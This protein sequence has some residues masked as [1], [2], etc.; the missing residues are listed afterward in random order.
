MRLFLSLFFLTSGMSS[1]LYQTAWQRLLGLFY[2]VGAISSA[3]VIGAFLFGLGL[4]SLFGGQLGRAGR[5]RTL[6][7]YMSIELGIGLFGIVSVPLVGSLGAVTAGADYWL[8]AV[9]TFCFLLF[10]T[11]LMGATLPVAILAL[12]DF[13]RDLLRN[14]SSYYF[15]N[16]IGA[17]IGCF[18]AGTVLISLVGLNG[19]IYLAALLN[20]LLA[21]AIFGLVRNNTR[22][23]VPEQRTAA[24]VATESMP[25]H[26]LYPAVFVS[27]FIAIGYEIIW[28]R[29]VGVLLKDSIYTFT[30]ML[31]IYLAAIA[32]G[33]RHVHR[34]AGI[35]PWKG[36]RNCYLALNGLIA[37]AVAGTVCT[38]YYLQGSLGDFGLDQLRQAPILP[39]PPQQWS[40][41]A[42]GA[43]PLSLLAC[44]GV[45]GF[46]IALPAYFM[47]A[48]FPLLASLAPDGVRHPAK[49]V[50][51]VYATAVFGNLAGAL[52]TGFVLLPVFGTE[53]TMLFF[54]LAGVSFFIFL[55][56]GGRGRSGDILYRLVAP[57]ALVVVIFVIFPGPSAVIRSLHV[58][59][60]EGTQYFA[61]GIEGVVLTHADGARLRH[62]INGSAH[63]GRPNPFFYLEAVQTLSSVDNPHNVLIIGLGTGSVLEAAL[64]DPKVRAITLVEINATTIKNLRKVE[65]IEAMLSHPKVTVFHDD[66]RRWLNRTG[67][68]FDVVMMDPLRTA[69]AFSN[70]IY[71]R[72]FF[73][74][75]ETHLVPGGAV[76]V[77]TDEYFVV[78]RTL[79]TIFPV[80]EQYCTYLIGMRSPALNDLRAARFDS[81]VAGFSPET[82]VA[83]RSIDCERRFNRE[84]ILG[85]TAS[86]PINTDYSPVTEYYL[87]SAVSKLLRS[88]PRL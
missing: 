43:L 72:E 68:R 34:I 53:R 38:F 2:G 11:A 58:R 54:V 83:I 52:G 65:L 59:L 33:S 50:S 20:L 1:L 70:N 80:V 26:L 7:A 63:G 49:A 35:I 61:E 9:C 19:T 22:L 13:D 27:G 87:G 60:T 79:A 44:F 69:S 40:L 36:P 74:Q 51:K 39:V 64:N 31:S 57:A 77:W 85:R 88:S 75:L 18:V 37:L 41:L 3:I 14:V 5:T 30:I 42:I 6:I 81:I 28:F 29:L 48:T 12:Q 71:S 17:A 66:A 78:P 21:A 15:M 32:F 62:F 45:A 4:G 67:Q 46:F 56:R 23:H 55:S 73:R 82:Q 86:V 76:M 10:P 84:E 47:G 16:T 24:P 8:A 25:P